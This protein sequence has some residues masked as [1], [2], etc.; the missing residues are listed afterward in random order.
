LNLSE[1]SQQI[2][3]F[4]DCELQAEASKENSLVIRQPLSESNY[5]FRIGLKSMRD[6]YSDICFQQ[7]SLQLANKNDL[8]AK[9]P[10]AIGESTTLNLTLSAKP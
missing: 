3:C 7:V 10:P 4:G 9:A 1:F 2:S 5:V 6:G 8:A